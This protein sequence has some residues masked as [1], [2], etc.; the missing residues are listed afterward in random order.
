MS[1]RDAQVGVVLVRA[2]QVEVVA[3]SGDLES[4]VAPGGGEPGDLLEGQIGP[5][6]GEQGDGRRLAYCLSMVSVMR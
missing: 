3:G 1:R 4:V 2:L 6:A 5:L